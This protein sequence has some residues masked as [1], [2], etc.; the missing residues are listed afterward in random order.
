MLKIGSIL[1][2]PEIGH[3]YFQRAEPQAKLQG[4]DDQL[5]LE[6]TT[7]KPLQ[8]QKICPSLKDSR[9][10]KKEPVVKP[11]KPT[12][13]HQSRKEKHIMARK[14]L[15]M[16]WPKD[17]PKGSQPRGLFG[18]LRDIFGGT[19][20]DMFV[21]KAGSHEAITPGDWG[22]WY[23]RNSPRLILPNTILGTPTMIPKSCS[24]TCRLQNPS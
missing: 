24:A 14:K 3:L 4:K 7:P 18:G 21:Q 16:V 1:L 5:E 13:D 10:K 8:R 20:P 19:G 2:S 15:Q 11:L 17:G 6:A 12:K 9:S 22:N 23:I